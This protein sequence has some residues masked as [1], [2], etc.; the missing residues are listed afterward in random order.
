MEGL[1]S[2][3]NLTWM[4][5][6][7]KKVTKNVDLNLNYFARKSESPVRC[8]RSV[9]LHGDGHLVGFGGDAL[10]SDILILGSWHRKMP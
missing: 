8:S 1:Q 9:S 5:N 2:G 6:I 4:L 7:Q 10:V 3:N